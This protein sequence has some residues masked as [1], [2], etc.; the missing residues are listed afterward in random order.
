MAGLMAGDPTFTIS[1]SYDIAKLHK[2]ANLLKRI[3]LLLGV[4]CLIVGG[5]PIHAQES[6]DTAIAQQLQALIDSA[7]EQGDPG[8][9]VWVDTPQGVFEGVGGYADRD[10]ETILQVDD[11]FRIGSVNKMFTSVVILQLMEEA[12][13]TLDDTLAQ[14]LSPEVAAMVS[15]SDVITLRQ[16]LN[17]SSGIHDYISDI[18]EEYVVNVEM[19]QRAWEPLELVS[20]IATQEA[21]FAPGEAWAYSNSNFVLLGMVIEASTG[22]S[23]VENYH[24]RI[25]D[26]LGLTHTYLADAETPT[27]NLIR[28]YDSLIGTNDYNA[29][30]TWT[31]GALVSNAPDLATFMRALVA[32]RLFAEATT[33]DIMLTP[34]EASINFDG[35]G[36]DYGLGVFIFQTPFGL[37][38]GHTGDIFGF[39][40]KAFY[41]ADYDT[42][43]INLVSTDDFRLDLIGQLEALSQ[44]PLT[45][46]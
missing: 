21:D 32:G 24:A 11:A 7:V 17:L 35:E 2:G 19:Q 38:Y 42:V 29:S 33:L 39:H 5:L 12:V 31:A 1:Y 9:V 18:E 22:Q 44:L 26:P 13:L 46:K 20:I 15:N 30:L 36:S 40:A 4:V 45:V 28:G 34:T 25:I 41:L 6:F 16:M 23:V 3:M 37:I 8:V 10:T 14:W 27:A 43:F